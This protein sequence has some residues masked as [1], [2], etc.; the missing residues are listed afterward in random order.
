[1]KSTPIATPRSVCHRCRRPRVTCL[2]PYITPLAT[3]TRFVLLT[4]PMESRKEKNG[5]GRVAHL[6]LSNSEI[7]VGVD[8]SDDP[9]VNGLID[10]PRHD[11]RLLY[12][13]H[14]ALNLTRRDYRPGPGKQPVLFLI[15]ATWPCAKK[16]MRQS[17]NLRRLP[18]VSFDS[19]RPSE[20]L[21]K[22][23]PDPMCLST[24]ETLQRVLELFGAAGLEKHDAADAR[25]LLQPFRQMIEM[26]LRYAADPATSRYRPSG[27]YRRPSQRRPSLK[28]S[29]R[30]V[31]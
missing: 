16:V 12:P 24:V 31:V 25:L 1:M 2:C 3:R 5:T 28:H 30:N 9:R 8:F 6:S 10:D 26:Q 17:D 29:R 21:I 14:A 4:H 22:H 27:G 18:R 13:G 23:Q 19:T 11:C 7:V 20:F 15:D